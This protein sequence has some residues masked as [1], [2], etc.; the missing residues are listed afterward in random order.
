LILA[1]DFVPLR[2]CPK[3]ALQPF[4]IEKAIGKSLRRDIPEG[5]YLRAC[6][7]D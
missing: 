6:D 7:F 5:D 4:E 2:P 1:N 3:D